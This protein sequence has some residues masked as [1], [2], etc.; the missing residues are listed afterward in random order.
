MQRPLR[1]SSMASKEIERLVGSLKE[2]LER[3]ERTEVQ[4]WEAEDKRSR[5]EEEKAELEKLCSEVEEENDQLRH[6]LDVARDEVQLLQN[7][8][9]CNEYFEQRFTESET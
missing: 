5:L 7:T 3:A 9:E 4:C 6:E 2:R 8:I 1:R